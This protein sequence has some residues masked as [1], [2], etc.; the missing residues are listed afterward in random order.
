MICQLNQVKKMY[1][2]NIIFEDLSLEVK[3]KERIG[4]VGRNGGGK[5]TLLRLMA[6]ITKPDEG[7]IHWKKATTIGYLEQIP[8]Q[9]EG[10]LVFDVLKQSNKEIVG[11]EKQ[12][13]KSEQMMEHPSL[14]QEMMEN[15]K[16]YGEVQER[17]TVLGGYEL[18]ANINRIATG[19]QIHPLLQMPFDQIS[20][21]EK[22]KVGL[23]KIL[24][25]NPDLLL[26]DEP[27]NHLDLQAVE[28]LG[29]FLNTYEGTVVIISHDRYFL[30]EVVE[31]ILDLEDG[32]LA[33][34]HTNFSGYVKEKEERLLREFQAYEEQQKKIKKMK[35]AIKRLKEWANRANPPNEGL[36]KRAKNMERALERME[37]I[38]KPGL[39]RKKMQMD[40]DS[41][42]RSGKDVIIM[43]NVQKQF[44]EK[45]LFSDVDMHIRYQDR[46]AIIGENGTGKSTLI[47]LMLG[48]VHPD[49]GEVMIGSNVKFGYLS[50]HVFHDIDPK[51]T[52][53]ETF[54]EA[55][56]VTEGKAR[57]ILAKFLFYGEHVFRKVT[58]L[59]GGEKMRLRLAQLMHQDINTLILDE[60]TNHLDIDSREVLEETL[61]GFAGSLIAVSHDR[62]FLDR[63]FDYLYWIE[64]K[65]ITKYPGNYSWAKEKRK[66]QLMEKQ[67][68]SPASHK[69]TSNHTKKSY[70]IIENPSI[71]IEKLEQQIE[72]LEAEI[73]A[74]ELK[75]AGTAEIEEL[76]HLQE[77]KAY[78]E[79]ER[80]KAYEKLLVL[81][82]KGKK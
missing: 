70:R 64:N 57:H 62:Y 81:E 56:S 15:V 10:M 8:E 5:T 6:G 63:Q 39:N 25:Q 49:E 61:E 34:Y 51:Q 59:S 75:M 37:K 54:R 40:L 36:H 21:G 66:E 58:Q 26:L 31:R 78:Q 24:L 19:L 22:T 28:W 43:K 4:I 16:A 65:Q 2:G 45:L 69:K 29:E 17:F 3:E 79:E 23:A 77:Q 20:G 30:D 80:Q 9:G 14:E 76:Q 42:D 44:A 33:V 7:N 48:N 60:P 11:L 12:M 46:V 53:L 71:I 27:T 55:I 38:E 18:E 32:D 52:V 72:T 82:N 68:E 1:G 67:E 50:Q 73:Y 35:E 74:I 47:Q 13:K 41:S